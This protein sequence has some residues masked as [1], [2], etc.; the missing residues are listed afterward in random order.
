MDGDRLRGTSE[1]S[2]YIAE[3][4]ECD[5]TIRRQLNRSCELFRGLL[6]VASAFERKPEIGPPIRIIWLEHHRPLDQ[7]QSFAAPPSVDADGSE[8]IERMHV[9]PILRQNL[10]INA[11]RLRSPAKTLQPV[12]LAQQL[13]YLILDDG[14]LVLD[15]P[16]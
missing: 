13:Y 1:R 14:G 10:S 7:G 9:I 2:K 11:F 12:S 5:R 15:A 8:Q 6:K 16:P 3:I 4:V